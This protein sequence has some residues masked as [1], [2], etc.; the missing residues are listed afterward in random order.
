MSVIRIAV[1]VRDDVQPGRGGMA[2]LDPRIFKPT[3]LG[4]LLAWPHARA[5]P[6]LARDICVRQFMAFHD[7]G[8]L[9]NV[10]RAT[11]KRLKACCTSPDSGYCGCEPSSLL[12]LCVLKTSG[13]GSTTF[14]P[15][16]GASDQ[17]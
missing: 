8:T 12:P 1:A 10:T 17:L 6:S 3:E 7:R 5:D 4:F 16:D 13:L 2:S 14:D 11:G 15:R 9:S